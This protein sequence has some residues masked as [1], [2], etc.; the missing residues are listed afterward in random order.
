MLPQTSLILKVLPAVF[1]SLFCYLPRLFHLDDPAN[2]VVTVGKSFF[3]FPDENYGIIEIWL[4]ETGK[5]R[6]AMQT[7]FLSALVCCL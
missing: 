3:A 7:E 6:V 4:P 2:I 1:G 5:E